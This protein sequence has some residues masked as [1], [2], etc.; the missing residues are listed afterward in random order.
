MLAN[1]PLHQ[2]HGNLAFRVASCRSH[3]RLCFQLTSKVQSS[4]EQA[5][6]SNCVCVEHR[7][8]GFI[9]HCTT[10]GKNTCLEVA[11]LDPLKRL[12]S[13]GLENS[14]AWPPLERWN[15]QTRPRN[16]DARCERTSDKIHLLHPGPT[17]KRNMLAASND[18]IVACVR[19]LNILLVECFLRIPVP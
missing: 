14:Q 12:T 10:S 2:W 3:P 1:S 6:E 9:T 13:Q 18:R 17:N 15:Q 4:T 19:A 8:Q 11:T 7:D 16:N 5:G